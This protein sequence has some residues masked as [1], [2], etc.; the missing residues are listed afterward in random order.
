[1][2]AWVIPFGTEV[3]FLTSFK[4]TVGWVVK[5]FKGC[6][7]III[8]LG[9]NLRPLLYAILHFNGL[10]QMLFTLGLELDTY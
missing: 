9:S 5:A 3:I 4:S 6:V 2:H 1:M 8:N 10:Q 7:P